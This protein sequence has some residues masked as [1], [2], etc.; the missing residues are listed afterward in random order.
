MKKARLGRWHLW[1]MNYLRKTFLVRRNEASPFR[2]LTQIPSAISYISPFSVEMKKARL[3][4]WHPCFYPGIDFDPSGCRNEESPFR[5]L[6]PI[7]ITEFSK[8]IIRVDIR[9]A[10]LAYW[11][12]SWGNT[13]TVLYTWYDTVTNSL[14]QEMHCI[15]PKLGCF[16]SVVCVS[17]FG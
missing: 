14:C 5:A 6:T 10:R 11:D 7:F 9:K 13:G 4:R 17:S 3:G 12:L 1:N 8:L 2:A 16:R 15:V